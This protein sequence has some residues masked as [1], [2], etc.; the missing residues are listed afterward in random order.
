MT[1]ARVAWLAV[2]LLVASAAALGGHDDTV[3]SPAVSLFLG[4]TNVPLITYRARRHLEAASRRFKKQAWLDC[5]TSLDESGFSY[6]VTSSGG[7]PYVLHK[8]LLA[9][10]D[11]ERDLIHEHP[12]AGFVETNYE[13]TDDGADGDWLRI[14][15]HPRR[16]D[17]LLLDGWL[18]VSP[19][20]GALVEANGRLSKAPSFW[21]TRVEVVRRHRQIAGVTV[22]VL[23]ESVASVRIA[24]PSTFSMRYD[25]DAIN[26]IALG[27]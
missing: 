19:V 14:K 15:L 20:D 2:A 4:R 11:A 1:R 3:A 13:M 24:G 9:A 25:Y 12:A 21:T 8:V 16:R 17:R 6:E 18:L 26:G 5:V 27:E 10:L 23:I 22:P 7:S